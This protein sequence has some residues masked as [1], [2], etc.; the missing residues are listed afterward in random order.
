[1]AY[2]GWG[3]LHAGIVREIP[4]GRGRGLDCSIGRGLDRRVGHAL[5]REWPI[6][7]T[8]RG[9][10]IDDGDWERGQEGEEARGVLRG[11]AS[12]APA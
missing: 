1:M 10:G 6:G 7:G 12:S 4:Y 11:S 8:F 3:R 5:E 9:H 2:V